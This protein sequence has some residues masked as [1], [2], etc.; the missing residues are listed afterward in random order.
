MSEYDNNNRSPLHGQRF[1]SPEDRFDASYIR[2][3]VSGCWL[4]QGTPRGSNNY[5]RIGVNGRAMQSHRYSWT[6]YN[7]KIPNGMYVLHK[8]DTPLC[9]N[10]DHLFLG[11]HQDNV[12]DCVRKG[13]TNGGTKTPLRGESNARSKLTESKVREIRSSSASARELA[14]DFG[15]STTLIYNVRKNYIWRHVK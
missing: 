12:D 14:D 6:R 10:P 11:T 13:R 1:M 4:W 2:D 8:C 5:G 3:S 9:V 7:G 15:V